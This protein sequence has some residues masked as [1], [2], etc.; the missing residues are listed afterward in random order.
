MGERYTDA[1]HMERDAWGRQSIMVSGGNG[2]NHKLG[3]QVFQN[4]GPGRGNGVTAVRY[5]DQVLRPH[6]VPHFAR[7]PNHVFQ[8]DNAYAHT[9]RL[10]RDFLQQHNFRTLP[11]PALSPDL[12]LIEHL[13]DEIQ[14]RLNDIRPRPITAAELA[15]AFQRVWNTVLIAFINRLIHSM[16]RRCMAVINA[17]GGHTHYWL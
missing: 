1:C 14:R 7:H 11:W 2:L 8:Q 9:A 12:N 10:T 3:P 17:N 16:Y 13:W 5:I 15:A 4:I 6:A